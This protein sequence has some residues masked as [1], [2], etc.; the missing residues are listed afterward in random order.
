M[1]ATL[2]AQ[3]ATP[4]QGTV[5]NKTTGKPSSGDDV[6]LI[7]LAQGMQESTHTTTDAKG[8]YKLDVPDDGIHLVRVTHDKANYFQPAP[9]GTETVDIDVYNAKE[10]VKGVS[11]E[12]DVIRMQTDASGKQLKVVEHFFIKNEST[13]PLTQ[14]SKQPFDFYLPDGAIVEGA[15]AKAPNGMPVQAPPVP[16]NDKNHYTFLFPIRPGETE[17]QV[18]YHLPYAGKID[19]APKLGTTVGALVVML[20]KSIQFTP[21]SG[22]PFAPV[23]EEPNA[24]TYL[25]RNVEPGAATGFSLSGTGELPRAAGSD[26]GS[27]GGTQQGGTAAGQNPN[28]PGMGLANPLDPNADRSP[29]AKYKWWILSALLLAMA[30]AAAVLLKKPAPL[31]A[32][33]VP[34]APPANDEDRTLLA[35]KEE[36]FALETERLSGNLPEA[37]YLAQK[38]AIELVLK[39]ALIRKAGPKA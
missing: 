22:S 38:S 25:A 21:V 35:L 23:E 8:H 33:Y 31:P 6:T 15:A 30:V 24:Q 5:I 10:H 4:I 9:P 16:L 34:P 3:A 32:A 37:E 29:W 12:A 28:A 7:R 20:P 27:N 19:L 2:A 11:T 14:F 1:A 18:T 13:P 36:L 26:Q 17:F 39:R